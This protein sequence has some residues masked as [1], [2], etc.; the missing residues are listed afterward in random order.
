M[1]TILLLVNCFIILN[2]SIS[3][4]QSGALDLSF[5]G[6]G[7]LTTTF[8][9]PIIAYNRASAVRQDGKILVIGNDSY[10]SNATADIARYNTDGSLDKTFGEGGKVRTLV[11]D[12]FFP[13][14]MAIQQDGKIVAAGEGLSGQGVMVVRFNANGTLDNSFSQDGKVITQVG[15]TGVQ[16]ARSIAIQ[17]DGKIV[18]AGLC[19]PSSAPLDYDFLVMRYNTDGTLDNS[20]NGT[21]IITRFGSS[22]DKAVAV[23]VLPNGRIVAA[24]YIDNNGNNDFIVARYTS[25]GKLDK[26]F[27]G[28]DGV[29]ITDIAG[30]DICRTLAVQADEKIIVG[31]WSFTNGTGYV[32]LIRY[33]T[34]GSLD[35]SFSGDG[36]HTESLGATYGAESMVIDASGRI[37]VGAKSNGFGT[38]I[39]FTTNCTLDGTFSGDG[40]VYTSLTLM[41]SSTNNDLDIKCMIGLQ[42]EK[43]ILSGTYGTFGNLITPNFVVFRYNSK[44]NIDKT[45]NSDGIAWAEFKAENVGSSVRSVAIQPDKKIVA[46]GA[47]GLARYNTNGTLDTTFNPNGQATLNFSGGYI[48]PYGVAIQTDGKIIVAGLD[49]QYSTTF[50]VLRLNSNGSLDKAF[51]NYGIVT[52]DFGNSGDYVDNNCLALQ[53]DGKIV[54]VGY[55]YNSTTSNYDVAIARYTTSGVLDN[56]FDGDGKVT[57]DIENRDQLGGAI[58]IQADGK[59]VVAGDAKNSNNNNDI[60]VFRYTTTGALDQTFNSTGIKTTDIA[61]HDDHGKSVKIQTDGKIVVGG[62]AFTNPNRDFAVVRYNANGSHD[63]TFSGNGNA[64]TAIETSS[65]DY[66]T[67]LAIQADGKILLGGY[68]NSSNGDLNNFALVR[69]NSNGT[70]DGSFGN[71]GKKLTDFGSVEDSAFSCALQP[72]GQLVM[73]GSSNGNFAVARFL[74][75]ASVAISIIG[76]PK[77]EDL[78]TMNTSTLLQQNIPNP[79]NHTTTINYTL[80]QTYSSA[81]IIIT[82]KSGKILKEVNVSAKGK[83]SL[84][85]DVSTLS[86]GAY[87]YS[88]YVDGKLVDTKQMVLAK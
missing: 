21:G 70:I 68:Y 73:A 63:N 28:G 18:V 84:K 19:H 59:I 13:W 61:Q 4:A 23:A 3:S 9:N 53:T 5:S 52:T 8:Y 30:E 31:G 33:N 60:A 69:Y 87:Q 47:R 7:K 1:K 80:P 41:G 29:V 2:I 10:G 17:N 51:G 66:G 56:T 45:F 38:I 82:D 11:G 26:Y 27:G 39:R 42:G 15:G 50:A 54:V 77:V 46:A 43:I 67:S 35:A 14:A 16:G 64:T 74:T 57:T 78:K 34:D 32:S 55:T 86:S 36:K 25:A 44:G 58:A 76:F 49:I 22:L 40:K 72:D 6:D 81:K 20:F 75:A 85:L 48:E 12:N 24:G 65:N 88:L 37:I 71:G 62:F 83:G 79:F